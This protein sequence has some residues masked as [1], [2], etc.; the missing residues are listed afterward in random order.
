VWEGSQSL[1]K[2]AEVFAGELG[3][4]GYGAPIGWDNQGGAVQDNPSRHDYNLDEMVE[5]FISAAIAQANFTKLSHQMWACGSDFQYQNADH[6]FHN[7]D[8]IMCAPSPFILRMI[9]LVNFGDGDG[10]AGTVRTM[11]MR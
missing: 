7:L 10:G 4:G 8:K 2:S 6:W 1:G 9:C 5:N 11:T 3:G